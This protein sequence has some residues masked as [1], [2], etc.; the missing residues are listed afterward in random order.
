MS[1]TA[2]AL[3]GVSKRFASVPALE[4][5]TLDI[6]RGE[7]LC[8]IGASGCGKSTLLNLV[9]GLDQPSRGAIAVEA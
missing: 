9:A 6:A 2:V 8:V 4:D 5:V 1:A 3:R 7:L